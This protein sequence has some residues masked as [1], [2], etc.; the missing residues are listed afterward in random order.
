MSNAII[1]TKDLAVGYDNKVLI[2]DINFE[3][4]KSE[5][6]V[7]I[8]P[9]GSG[10]STILKTITKQLSDLGGVVY[11]RDN[12]LKKLS[13]KDVSKEMSLLLTKQ[14][15]PDYMSVEEM[16]STGRYPYT[17]RF[18]VLSENDKKIVGEYIKAVDLEDIKDKDF[19]LISDGQRQRVML[20]RALCQEPEILIMDEPTS[21]LDIHYKIELISILKKMVREKNIA[22]VMSLHELDLAGRCADKLLCI[23]NGHIDRYGNSDEIFLDDGYIEELYGVEKGSYIKE[24]GSI[25]LEK[26]TG[27]PKTF[28]ISGGGR[29]IHIYRKLQK[30]GIP[31]VAGII[32]ENDI[33]Y[34]IANALATK[35]IRENSFEEIKD[36]NISAAKKY[37]DL[38]DNV[39]CTLNKFGAMNLKLKELVSYA[40]EK[41][42]LCDG[43]I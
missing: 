23:S 33:E 28:V 42:K 4:K 7:L 18:G 5:I 22:V 37:I 24:Y 12:E 29:G 26:I 36:E 16:V 9:N 34:P 14:P 40:K 20:A 39:I 32:Y 38:C 13:E 2:P 21:Y 1:K 10:K 11:L 43:G 8:G 17:G 41:N 27:N 6:L 31:F 25:E 30:S 15:N 19:N 3:V 35:V